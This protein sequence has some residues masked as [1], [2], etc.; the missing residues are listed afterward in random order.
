MRNVVTVVLEYPSIYHKGGC[1]LTQCGMTTLLWVDMYSAVA[2]EEC[3]VLVLMANVIRDNIGFQISE[4]M[5][6]M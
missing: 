2:G 4:E 6:S 5:R 1:L 3:L